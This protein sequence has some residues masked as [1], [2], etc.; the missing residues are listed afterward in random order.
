MMYIW[1]IVPVVI[2]LI[3]VIWSDKDP[4]LEEKPIVKF[5]QLLMKIFGYCLG[6]IVII[7]LLWGMGIQLF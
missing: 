7:S 1:F 4:S 3:Y 5:I 2:G 6:V